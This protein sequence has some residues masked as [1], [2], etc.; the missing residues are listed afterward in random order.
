MSQR[1]LLCRPQGGLNDIFCQIE[2]CCQYAE[3]TARTVIVDTAYANSNFFRDQFSRYFLSKQKR[4]ILSIGNQ[5]AD[6]DAMDVYPETIQGRLNSYKVYLDTKLHAFCDNETN[7]PITFDFSRDHAHPLLVHHQ[8]GGGNLSRLALLRLSLDRSLVDE[9]I[10]R[11]KCIGGPWIGIHVRNTDYSTNYV[12][13]LEELKQSSAKRIFLAT[14]SQQVRDHFQSEL[15]NT[16]LYSFSRRLSPNGKPLH[17]MDDTDNA[18]VL[19][20]NSDAILDLVMLALSSRLLFKKIAPN[21]FGA[22]HSGYGMLALNCWNSKIL[23]RHF[24][25]DP[26]IEFGLG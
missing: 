22:S 21:A 17:K 19:T 23:L 24:I 1:F 5:T 20:T 8:A 4:L 25:S 14:D 18:D 2:K 10:A 15:K 9:L 7:R 16:T 13:L 6:I 3:F 12:S 26:R 11:I